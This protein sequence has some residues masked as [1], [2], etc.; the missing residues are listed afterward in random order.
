MCVC[1]SVNIR[2]RDNSYRCLLFVSSNLF[3]ASKY[4]HLTIFEHSLPCH[5]SIEMH[6]YYLLKIPFPFITLLYQSQGITLICQKKMSV[7]RLHDFIFDIQIVKGV[8]REEQA[9]LP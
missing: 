3:V 8:S 1:A 9:W 2:N 5:L 7:N 6:M 4:K